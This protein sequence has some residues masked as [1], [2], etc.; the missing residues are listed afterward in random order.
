LQDAVTREHLSVDRF[1][2]MHIGAT[3]RAGLDKAVQAAEK[4]NSPTGVL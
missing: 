4:E 1:F 2:M 3:A